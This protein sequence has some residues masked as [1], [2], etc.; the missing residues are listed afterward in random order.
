MNCK[1]NKDDSMSIQR[2]EAKEFG[3]DGSGLYYY[4]ISELDEFGIDI[5][6][7]P[8]SV[9]I[10]LE[11]LLRHYDG[12]SVTESDIHKLIE[13]KY[14]S[15]NAGET[16]F[17]VGR[18]AMHDLGLGNLIDLATLREA[19]SKIGLPPESVNPVLPVDIVID[20]SVQVDSFG[21]NDAFRQN[22]LKEFRRNRE[23]YEF[24]KWVSGSFDNIRVLPPSVGIIHQVNL[25]Y[26]SKLV[27]TEVRNGKKV[28]FPDTVIGMDSHT[29]MINGMG[30]LGWGVGGIEAMSA[31]LGEPLSLRIPE[32]VGVK[33]KGKRQAGVVATDIVLRITELLRK[34]GV[35][36]KF[37][38]FFG[39]SVNELSVFDRATISNM[40]PEYGATVGL[41]PIDTRTLEFLRLTGRTEEQ[42]QLV[43]EYYM[44]QKM[45]GWSP[46]TSY[47]EVVELDLSEIGP[48]LAGPNLPQRRIILSDLPGSFREFSEADSGKYSKEGKEDGFQYRH[49]EL[50]LNG[51][52]ENL[53]DGDI[54]IAAITSC[55][56]TSN[57]RAMIGAGILARNAVQ[58]GL[59]IDRRIKTSLSPG[60]RVV[61]EYYR[62]SGLQEYLDKLGF[63]ITGFGCMTCGGKGGPLDPALDEAINREGIR[64]VAVISSNRNF[65][66][67]IN[68]SV[69]ANYIMSPQLVIALAL[70]GNVLKDYS[71]E[72]I[73]YG[74]NGDPVYLRDVWP[75]DDEITKITE[76]FVTED[77]F[78]SVY[79]QIDKYSD[80]WRE[81]ESQNDLL[82][83]WD[84]ESTYI[85]RSPFMDEDKIIRRHPGE[86][87]ENMYTLLVLGDNVSTDHISPESYISEEGDAGRFLKE[88]G[89]KPT[90]FN[91]FGSRRGNPEVKVR[92]AFSNNRVR[93][94]LVDVDGGF[95]KHFPDGRVLSVFQASKEYREKNVQTL[96]FAGDN[97]GMGSSRDW[98]AKG[99]NLLGICAVVAN[100]FER[101]H[102]DNLVRLGVLPL[103]FLDGFGY[104]D[105]DIDFSH[106]MSLKLPDPIDVGSMATLG[107]VNN[108]GTLS[109][110]ELRMRLDTKKEIRYYLSGGIMPYTL[111]QY[112]KTSPS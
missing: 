93:N 50:D 31:M 16:P 74:N 60:S 13:W 28:V 23:R 95:T 41:F 6:R 44:K 69:K 1:A 58:K 36:G 18:I 64:A 11:S 29:P 20:H 85:L 46:D 68:K 26:L 2:I 71:K 17:Y 78:K 84:P 8:N 47:S 12:A 81:L 22:Q 87:I 5:S 43:M 55:T 14:Q 42:V 96:V 72:P 24:I 40:C 7:I 67:R 105:L 92:G 33:L 52:E 94:L 91:T 80:L 45:F 65:E 99:T 39:E 83:H 77:K 66:S 90:D 54:V 97:Y 63:N 32:V 56:N 73:G 110:V 38:E 86:S 109:Y 103:Q 98:A 30:I 70:G 101:I 37:V 15:R 62:T 3:K 4:S 108:E 48:N 34:K 19:A 106:K 82:Y 9:K 112:S 51:H 21:S 49:I 57:P 35:V 88:H 89:V 79:S 76:E 102:R 75:S 61:E 10:I 25:E 53:S 27:S 104:K 100:S 59:K 107:Y 111:E